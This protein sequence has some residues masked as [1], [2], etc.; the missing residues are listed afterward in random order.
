VTDDSS[1]TCGADAQRV[2]TTFGTRL[3]DVSLLAPDSIVN[4]SL[5][6]A[7]GQ[8]ATPALIASWQSSPRAAPGRDVSNPWPIRVDV[9][10]NDVEGSDCRIAAN[11]IYV[12]TADTSTVVERRPVTLRVRRTDRWRISDFRWDAP[13]PRPA[14]TNTNATPD[15]GTA[16]HIR[17]AADVVR[18]YYRD[19][20]RRDFAAA[21]ALWSD[22]GRASGKT[23]EAFAAGFAETARVTATVADT[24]TIEGAAGSQFV[25]VPVSVDAVLRSGDHQHFAGTYTLRRVMVEGATS[26]QR[27]W[28]IFKAELH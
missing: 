7:Y 9:G 2:V 23:R 18:R 22:S 17:D 21:Y 26:A 20:Q 12:T 14:A 4:R 8:L 3:R 16:A 10:S 5:A 27:L 24:G 15:D 19:L 13:P 6:T 1:A 28:H 25:T 11:V